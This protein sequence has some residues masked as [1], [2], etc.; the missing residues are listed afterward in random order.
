MRPISIKISCIISIAFVC[1]AVSVPICKYALFHIW[2]CY[3]NSFLMCNFRM[4]LL[5]CESRSWN[6]V[7]LTSTSKCDHKNVDAIST[8][9]QSLSAVNFSFF[10]LQIMTI[11]SKFSSILCDQMSYP[12]IFFSFFCF[13]IFSYL[14]CME[15]KIH[16]QEEK[17]IIWWNGFLSCVSVV[18]AY[19]YQKLR[20]FNPICT[21]IL[22]RWQPD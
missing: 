18:K 7:A 3:F 14:I 11:S 20:I 10:P 4:K 9:A 12:F 2:S 8:N 1:A 15:N 17:I 5:G 6:G 13:I 19:S 16:T 22:L 21:H